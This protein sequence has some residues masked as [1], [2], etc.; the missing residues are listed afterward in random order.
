MIS[1]EIWDT[2]SG[3]VL[4]HGYNVDEAFRCLVTHGH[5]EHKDSL[6]LSVFDR[7]GNS[8]TMQFDLNKIQDELDF[9][10]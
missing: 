1:Y 2:D 6:R 5:D 8:I 10:L 7:H 9:S 4:W 3:N